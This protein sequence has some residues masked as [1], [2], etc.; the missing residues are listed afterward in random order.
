MKKQMTQTIYDADRDDIKCCD[1]QELGQEKIVQRNR[2][3]LKISYGIHINT[4]FFLPFTLREQSNTV[5]SLNLKNL[6]LSVN[7]PII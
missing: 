7:I 5:I 2:T 6:T 4:L 3:Y 1:K